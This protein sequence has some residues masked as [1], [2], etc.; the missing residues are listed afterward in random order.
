MSAILNHDERRLLKNI[1]KVDL[2]AGD[3]YFSLKRSE[4][5]LDW[6]KL[7][8]NA[9]HILNQIVSA[10]IAEQYQ[11]MGLDHPDQHRIEILQDIAGKAVQAARNSANFQSKERM[12]EIIEEFS[13]P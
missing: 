7:T 13:H 1:L 4:S 10:S 11:E 8:E 6:Y 3:Y 9:R 2:S 5:A 12:I